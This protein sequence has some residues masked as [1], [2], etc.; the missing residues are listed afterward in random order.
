MSSLRRRMQPW[1]KDRPI[2]SGWLVLGSEVYPHAPQLRTLLLE[3][4]PALV[5][6]DRQ[7]QLAFALGHAPH[8]LDLQLVAIGRGGKQGIRPRALDA[9]HGGAQPP[10]P[11]R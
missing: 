2:V 7:V 11:L 4:H 1:L 6:G 3:V 9:G 5:R 8:Q 10:D